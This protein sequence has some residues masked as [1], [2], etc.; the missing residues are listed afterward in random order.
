MYD[1]NSIPDMKKMNKYLPALVLVL[2]VI[3]STIFYYLKENVRKDLPEIIKD[4]RLTVLI[5]TGEHGFTRDSMKVYGFQYEIIKAF[6]DSIGVEL[7]VINEDN[8]KDG[9]TSLKRG[10]CDMLVSL[11]PVITDTALSIR[12]LIPIITTRLML[13]QNIDGTGKKMINKQYELD[14]DTITLILNSPYVDRINDLSEEIAA[15]ITLKE[16]EHV[17]LDDIV[18]MV[19]DNQY[20]YTVCPEY[21]APNLK[22]RYPTIDISLPL[23]FR[24]DLSWIVNRNSNELQAR[25]NKFLE[26]F[27][28]SPQF[29]L[30]YNQYFLDN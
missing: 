16:V 26:E 8:S 22:R 6:S 13:V 14:K 20:T 1:F 17:S 28:S 23:S 11:R 24:Q 19:V 25:L 27:K 18:K 29:Q 4:G 10:E 12:S 9:I 2:I 30:L 7:L 15:E 21:L 3:L 5:E